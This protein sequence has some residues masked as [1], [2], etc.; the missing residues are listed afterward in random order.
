MDDG[1]LSTAWDDPQGEAPQTA[2]A[3]G[4][5][6]KPALNFRLALTAEG[7]FRR[8]IWLEAFFIWFAPTVARRFR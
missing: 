2:A 6:P 8:P 4:S 7:I 1:P 5:A 3:P